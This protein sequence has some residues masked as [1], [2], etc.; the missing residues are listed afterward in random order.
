MRT[1]RDIWDPHQ[2]W[3]DWAQSYFQ[4][5]NLIR[6]WLEISPDMDITEKVSYKNL[7]GVY[8]FMFDEHF[9]VFAW[10]FYLFL[11]AG[12]LKSKIENEKK[13]MTFLNRITFCNLSWKTLTYIYWS[14]TAIFYAN[15]ADKWN[16]DVTFGLKTDGNNLHHN[17]GYKPT[18]GHVIRYLSAF[19]RRGPAWARV[20]GRNIQMTE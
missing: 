3:Q 14:L 6:C 9:V 16:W 15:P 8:W 10:H 1:A 11:A 5:E 4:K 19:F 13:S 17:G 2:Q 7:L 18:L 20:S 12:I